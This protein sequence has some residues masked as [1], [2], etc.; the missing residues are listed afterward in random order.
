MIQNFRNRL[1]GAAMVAVCFAPSIWAQNGAKQPLD[2]V[3]TG[4][5]QEDLGPV[6]ERLDRFLEHINKLSRELDNISKTV[7]ENTARR[8]GKEVV[9][10]L[11]TNGKL[12]AEL[13][14]AIGEQLTQAERQ[15]AT[16]ASVVKSI[17][18][19][20]RQLEAEAKSNARTGPTIW[21]YRSII[22]ASRPVMEQE[23]N[24][25]GAEGW[26]FFTITPFG[27]GNA[28]FARRPKN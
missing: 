4:S 27:R 25:L 7:S 10:E 17:G 8:A 14:K 6:L 22:E 26:E 3:Q 2:L 21:E 9:V 24:R 1:F 13:K 20:S 11:R 16:L 28:A 12:L 19:I 18:G 5:A 15:T 23:M